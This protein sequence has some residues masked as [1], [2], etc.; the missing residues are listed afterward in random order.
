VL[1]FY[2]QDGGAVGQQLCHFGLGSGARDEDDVALGDGRT[3]AG[4]RS[5]GVAGAGGGDDL[6][7]PLAGLDHGDGRGAVFEGGR[8]LAAIVLDP[9]VLQA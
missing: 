1:R 4:E 3:Q 7:P 9:Q 2:Q 6:G 8:G 5:G